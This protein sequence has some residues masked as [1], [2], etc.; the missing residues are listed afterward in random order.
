M[1]GLVAFAL[2]LGFASAASAAEF[3]RDSSFPANPTVGTGQFAFDL[4][5]QVSLRATGIDGNFTVLVNS[6]DGSMALEDPH[7]TL[8]ALGLQ[9]IPDLQIHQVIARTG[10][11]LVCGTHPETGKGCMT[12]GGSLASFW[13]PIREGMLARDSEAFFAS[14]TLTDQSAVPCCQPG[15]ENLTHMAGKGASGE[16]LA[17]WFDPGAA[18]VRT[19]RPFL[20]PGVGIMKDRIS[21]TN[22]VVRHFWVDPPE[23]QSPVDSIMMHLDRLTMGRNNIDV[24]DYPLV[25]A[26]AAPSIGDALLLSDWMRAQGADIQ[27]LARELES[28]LEGAAGADCR[29]FYRDRIDEIEA[30]MKARVLEFGIQQGLPGLGD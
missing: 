11:L 22:R 10:E 12:L 30:Q 18:T 20:G 14:A 15:T 4:T 19:Q 13:V 29:A 9:D 28:C 23:G 16:T 1:K 27:G 8:W 26:F 21:R 5:M 2:A 7:T 24:S 3:D 25:T 17:F 6:R